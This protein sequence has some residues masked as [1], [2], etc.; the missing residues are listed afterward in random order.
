MRSLRNCFVFLVFLILAGIQ[1]EVKCQV[2]VTQ[3][4]SIGLTPQEFVETYLVGT[5]ITVSNAKYNGSSEPL[6]SS[7]RTPLKSRD[8]IG[9]FTASGGAQ[10]Q[11]GIAGGVILSTGYT[12]KVKAG[13]NP[14]DD[15]WGN[16]QPAESDPDLV[17]LAGGSQINDKSVLEFDF[18]PQTDVVT[19][20]YVFGSIEFDGFCGSINDAFGLFLSGPGITG[21]SGFANNAVNIALLPNSTNYVNIFN[22]CDADQGNLGAGV[23]SWWNLKKDYY[24]F[25]R[26]TWVFT[27]T[28]NI[29]CNQ[30]Y[31]MKFAI[32]D[33][34][35]GVLDSGVF[36]EQNSFTSN[37][38][39]STTSFTNPLT[40][41]L[42]VEGCNG[43]S[44]QYAIPQTK[45]S[46]LVIDLNIHP[47]GTA[48]QADIT[49]NPFPL[50]LT[51][52]AGQLTTPA[53]LINAVADGIAEPVENLIIKATTTTCGI[54]NSVTSEFSITDYHTLLVDLN[55]VNICDGSAATLSPVVTGGQPILPGNVFQYLWSNSQTTASI[56]VSPPF[57]HHVYSVTVTDAC[58][59]VVAKT[60]SVDVGTTPGP[61]GQITGSDSICTPAS[62]VVYSMP[63]ITGA[64]V[65][66]WTIPSGG[67][68][69]SGANT[70]SVTVNFNMATIPGMLSVNGH[71]T[72]CGD[73]APSSMNI[74]VVPSV[75]P[76]GP[77]TGPATVCEGS[78]A[79][80]YSIPA[81]GGA[82]NYLWTLPAGF[83]ITSGTG[84]PQIT[85]NVAM[86]ASGGNIS[87]SGWNSQC[88]SGQPAIKTVTVDPVPS[89]AGNITAAGGNHICTPDP[90]VLFNVGPILHAA[91]YRWNYSG[92][93]GTIINNG[94]EAEISFPGNSSSGDLTVY[95][96]NNCGSGPVSAPYALTVNPRPVVSYL[97]LNEIKTTK[98]ARPVV[99]HGGIPVGDGGVYTGTGVRKTSTGEFIFD[100]SDN[101]V[102]ISGSAG[103]VYPVTYRYT[104][105]YNC[106]DE[107]TFNIRVF[108]SNSNSPC[109][110]TIKDVRDNREYRTF[111]AGNGIN[112]RCWTAVDLNYGDYTDQAV[113]QTDNFIPEKYCFD[114]VLRPLWG[115]VSMG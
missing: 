52:P 66:Q 39:T 80:S 32:G 57:G 24:S 82:E 30:T 8:E 56:V 84:S 102:T 29:Q 92:I 5:G 63:P 47:T 7:L 86:G 4:T 36:L 3:G 85:C 53:I 103:T 114:N 25:N 43:V 100:P 46:D 62:G 59:Q 64:D 9:S 72:Y 20:R 97:P 35:D 110:G 15:M 28:Y 18:V 34:S 99:L 51:I 41:Q 17:I 65:Y 91:S 77:L 45:S 49:P 95:G 1:S 55:N 96:I 27:A 33:A 31:H 71:S 37:N 79:I 61:A 83:T 50:H 68:I 111:L 40:G 44:L 58:G 87:V 10:T 70:N 16:S 60:V 109:P 101:S 73:G 38:I 89:P 67:T 112:A 76:A 13:S 98:N 22:I 106:I 75:A 108:A 12:G 48:D 54:S 23:Y 113:S 88:G 14:D 105:T 90:G 26:I 11:M 93:S 2:V 74:V 107:K 81:T 69:V 94:T 6:N 42:L 78:S 104:N 19:F 21:T 115:V